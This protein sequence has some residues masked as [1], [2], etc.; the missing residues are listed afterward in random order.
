MILS[1]LIGAIISSAFS[2]SSLLSLLSISL[3][4][5][6]KQALTIWI[7]QKN[8]KA[9]YI[10]SGQM[11]GA[12]LLILLAFSTETL[13]LLP[14]VLIPMTYIASLY[15]LGEHAL[16]TEL[17]GF[18]VLTLSS[19]I[20]RFSASGII[21]IPLYIATSL[22]FM[23][24]VLKVRIQLRKRTID[25]AVMVLYLAFTFIV[26][27]LINIPVITLIPLMDNL[28]FSLTLYRVRLA[29]TGWIEVAKSILF[30]ILSTSFYQ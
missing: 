12:T 28:L 29:V 10:F 2:F 17:S 23:A 27:S 30:V 5:N 8:Q 11:I 9:F 1:F 18:A 25:R 3:F 19:L 22:F 20:A 15:F 16:F 26:Y 6:S 4:I 13:R 24:G 14:F 21:D 7:R